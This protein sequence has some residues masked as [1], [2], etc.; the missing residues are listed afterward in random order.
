MKCPPSRENCI[1]VR[2]FLDVEMSDTPNDEH[3]LRIFKSL[4]DGNRLKIVG[5]LARQAYSVEQLAAILNLSPSTL[6]HHLKLLHEA[7]LVSAHAE[8]YYNIYHLEKGVMENIARS[9]LSNQAFPQ[10]ESAEAPYYDKVIKDYTLPDG[11][12]KVIPAQRRKLQLI[13]KYVAQAFTPGI[14]YTEREVNQRL[15]RYH[16]DTATL[17]RELV[18]AHIM[19][20]SAGEYWLEESD[21]A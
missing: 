1:V 19:S 2:K 16:S 18:G 5:L 8:S 3:L 13:L 21:E 10:P 4:A 20:R 17:R 9:L 12:L 7:G 6:S 14:R 11:R 15:S